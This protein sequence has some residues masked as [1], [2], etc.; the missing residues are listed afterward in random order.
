MVNIE[1]IQNPAYFSIFVF[2]G[3]YFIIIYGA[4]DMLF[5]ADGSIRQ[6]GVGFRQKTIFPMWLFSIILGILCYT[7]VQ[8]YCLQPNMVL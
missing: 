4:P 2:V 3:L 1:I 6:F 7:A 8:L 5:E